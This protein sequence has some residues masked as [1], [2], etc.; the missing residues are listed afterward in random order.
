MMMTTETIGVIGLGLIGASFAQAAQ[1]KGARVVGSDLSDKTLKAALAAGSIDTALPVDEIADHASFLIIAVPVISIEKVLSSLSGKIKP[2][3]VVVDVGSC[4]R[5]V[6]AAT[7]KLPDEERRRFVPSHP[8]AG[9]ERS[10]FEAA[11][12]E[13]FV[14]RW[15]VLC[16]ARA[17]ADAVS[18]A[19]E[20]WRFVGAKTVEMTPEEHDST[21]GL[22]SHLPHLLSY[23]LVEMIEKRG[24]DGLR[25]A[26][27]GFRDF[28]RIAGSHPDMWR[29]IF[30]SNADEVLAALSDYQK[31]LYSFVQIIKEKDGELLHQKLSAAR[32]LRQKW[33]R[34]LE[35]S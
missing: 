13:L 35:D 26:A 29:D 14:N 25:Y 28:T 21:F 31:T 4:K 34:H 11:S 15:T 33:M 7:G 8:I 18:Q 9:I 22:I 32:Q 24:D 3:S 2:D 12:A 10:G 19:H 1:H 20:A 16:P 23:A 6:V 5:K 30:L 27:G 17:D